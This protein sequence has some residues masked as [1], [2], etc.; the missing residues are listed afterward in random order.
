MHPYVG[1]T[2]PVTTEEV[3]AIISEY[4]A[5]GYSMSSNHMPM[6]GFL[7]SYKTLNGLPTENRRYPPVG[8]IPALLTAARGKVFPAIHYNSREMETLSSQLERLFAPVYDAALCR[9]TQLNIIWPPIN[10]LEMVKGTMPGLQIIFQLSHKAMDGRTP[11][12]ISTEICKYGKTID[13][14]LIDPSGGRG[15]EFDIGNSVMLYYAIREKNPRICV[16]FAGGFTGDNVAERVHELIKKTG[17]SS[18]CI[19]AEG[20]LR[21]K[22]TENYGDDLLNMGKVRKYLQSA[23]SVLP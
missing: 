14:V 20:G 10:Q 5:A 11:A 9:A 22:V 23:A 8:D 17:D 6:I 16:G 4:A 1:I 13:Y 7:A 18:F 19:D 15:K 21:D 2:G 12:Q 3:N